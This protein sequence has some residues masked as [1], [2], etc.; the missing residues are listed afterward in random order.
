MSHLPPD[1]MVALTLRCEA[2]GWAEK[3]LPAAAKSDAAMTSWMVFCEQ[4][5]VFDPDVDEFFDFKKL[6]EEWKTQHA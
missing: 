6:S 3:N 2:Q 5:G 1:D 4:R